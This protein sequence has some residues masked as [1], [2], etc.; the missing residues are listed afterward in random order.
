MTYRLEVLFYAENVTFVALYWVC[1]LWR[2]SG[3]QNHKTG[4]EMEKQVETPEQSCTKATS[5]FVCLYVRTLGIKKSEGWKDSILIGRMSWALSTCFALFAWTRRYF[6]RFS[7]FL[8]YF[9]AFFPEKDFPF[10]SPTQPILPCSSPTTCSDRS[11]KV[12][13]SPF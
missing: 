11:M 8:C 5:S 7:F 10:F 3:V 2:E 12:L 6:F 13:F 1:S 4:V 9:F